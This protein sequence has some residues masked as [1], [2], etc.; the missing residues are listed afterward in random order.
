M[1]CVVKQFYGRDKNLS[2]ILRNTEYVS[3]L[4]FN[5]DIRSA[6]IFFSV[7]GF[8]WSVMIYLLIFL[9]VVHYK[10]FEKIPWT[11]I[12]IY[13]NCCSNLKTFIYL[14]LTNKKKT[15]VSNVLWI[16]PVFILSIL[17]AVKESDLRDLNESIKELTLTDINEINIFK[18]SFNI[19]AY[20]SAAVSNII[21]EFYIS[22]SF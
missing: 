14:F 21:F 4:E 13:L 10:I 18:Y 11:L 6:F 20:A 1:A 3:K 12:V 7:T 5:H 22:Y 17:S 8:V 16:L 15:L 19:G 9:N 2:E